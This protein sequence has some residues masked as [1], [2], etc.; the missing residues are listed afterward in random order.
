ME[1]GLDETFPIYSG[2]LGILAGDILK[3]ARDLDLPIGYVLTGWSNPLLPAWSLGYVYLPAFVGMA[4]AG[5]LCAPL[6]A[7][8]AHALPAKRLKQIFGVFLLLIAARM[9]IRLL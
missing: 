2:G 1:F 8:I 4:V 6:G 7:R 3:T 9:L 5:S